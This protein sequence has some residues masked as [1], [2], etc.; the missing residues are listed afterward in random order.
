M[1]QRLF[2]S[3]FDIGSRTL[4]GEPI[5]DPINDLRIDER[6]RADEIT[7]QVKR[8]VLAASSAL[9][10]FANPPGRKVMLLAAGGWPYN[11]GQ[12]VV[13]DRNRVL[14]GALVDYCR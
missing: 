8:A 10:S 13:R 2:E 7:A 5:E 3:T 1:F 4:D 14:T 6:M 9:R 12:W 11:P